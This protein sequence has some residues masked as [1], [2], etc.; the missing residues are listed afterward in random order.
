MYVV[1]ESVGLV[2]DVVGS[3]FDMFELFSCCVVNIVIMVFVNSYKLFIDIG[4]C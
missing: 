3:D 1:G 4:I 2:V